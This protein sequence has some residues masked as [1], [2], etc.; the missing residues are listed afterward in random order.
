VNWRTDRGR[1]AEGLAEGLL[2]GDE[3][4]L[5]ECNATSQFVQVF[6]RRHDEPFHALWR[7]A[8]RFPSKASAK[9]LARSFGDLMM[10]SFAD[11]NR[12]AAPRA[13]DA[14]ETGFLVRQDNPQSINCY[15]SESHHLVRT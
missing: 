12:F 8:S 9:F 14:A 13:F 5:T 3:G 11:R 15:F 10:N 2:L 6:G 1:R 4:T 7:P